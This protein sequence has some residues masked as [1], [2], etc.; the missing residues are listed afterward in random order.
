[1]EAHEALEG[2][3]ALI[4]GQARLIALDTDPTVTRHEFRTQRNQPTRRRSP[5]GVGEDVEDDLPQPT[6]L[7]RHPALAA[8]GAARAPPLVF[9]QG[10]DVI[11]DKGVLSSC[12]TSALHALGL[13]IVA[14]FTSTPEEVQRFVARK[15]RP[16]TVVADPT[17]SAHTAYGIERSLWRKRKLK[18]MV[19]RVPTLLKGLRMVGLAGLNTSN[20][21][22]ADF[23]IDERGRI[24][25]AHYG[26][27][28]GDRIPF[29][30]VELFLAHGLIQRTASVSAEVP[31]PAPMTSP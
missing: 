11:S 23:L 9:G 19:T 31:D 5:K 26:S 18:A 15:P 4:H 25:E 21:M 13:D 12:D 28:A 27:D 3:F 7:E 6:F 10:A 1:M 29:E 22:P 30:Q 20:L 16:F 2:A 24:A 17:S 8:A 14:V